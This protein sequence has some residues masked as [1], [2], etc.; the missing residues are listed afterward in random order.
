MTAPL[1][2][3]L[4]GGEGR[5][6]GG[7]KPLRMLRGERL[8]DRAVRLGRTWSDDVR[9]SLRTAQQA[10]VTDLPMLLDDS[11]IEGPLAGLQSALAAAR[12]AG[13]D[14]VLTLP[15]DSPFLPRDLAGR[16][17]AAM[18]GERAAMAA[19]DGDLHPTC[20]LWRADSLE[21][22]ADYV[23]SGRRSLVGFAE[24]VGFVIV[25]WDERYFFNVNRPEDLAEAE[26]RLG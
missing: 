19:S 14:M 9:L 23:K 18:G 5:R 8:V 4:A 15:C 12:R 16:L 20:T 25:E 3:I 1:V 2:V 7:A 26:R 11:A 21:R 10:A 24:A 6:M 22:L 13:R 17:E